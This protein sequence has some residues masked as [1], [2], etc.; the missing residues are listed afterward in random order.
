MTK[1]KAPAAL[2]GKGQMDPVVVGHM[3]NIQKTG[4]QL[5]RFEF[6]APLVERCRQAHS[7]TWN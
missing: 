2:V 1:R 3:Q 4:A 5:S 6:L 7:R